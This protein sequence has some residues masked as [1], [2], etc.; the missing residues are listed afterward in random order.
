[1]TG[2]SRR[3]QSLETGEIFPSI[4]DAAKAIGVYPQSFHRAILCGSKHFG[5]WEVLDPPRLGMPVRCVETGE[6]FPSATA[7]AKATGSSSFMV[8]KS[9]RKATAVYTRT[10]KLRFELL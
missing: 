9:A 10:G 7:A 1:M 4:T 8:L 6:I 5:D 3:V 2:P